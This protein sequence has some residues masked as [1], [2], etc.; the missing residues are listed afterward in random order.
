MDCLSMVEM[1]RKQRSKLP[2]EISRAFDSPFGLDK[3]L[4]IF[5]FNEFGID[6]RNTSDEGII[7]QQLVEGSASVSNPVLM[8]QDGDLIAD[9]I[10]AYSE[11]TQK[12]RDTYRLSLSSLVSEQ[13]LFPQGIQPFAVKQLYAPRFNAHGDLVENSYLKVELRA[14]VIE[15]DPDYSSM[16]TRILTDLFEVHVTVYQDAHEVGKIN[17]SLVSVK[18][19]VF[20]NRPV[21]KSTPTTFRDT[22]I[23]LDCQQYN[24]ELSG[25]VDDLSN[26]A[27][28]KAADRDLPQAT[29]MVT[30]YFLPVMARQRQ[31]MFHLHNVELDTE[32]RSELTTIL[33][34]V[35]AVFD[36]PAIHDITVYQQHCDYYDQDKW[37]ALSSKPDI[38]DNVNKKR[39]EWKLSGISVISVAVQKTWW[40]QSLVLYKPARA[41]LFDDIDVVLFIS[42]Q[43]KSANESNA[44]K[45]FNNE[46]DYEALYDTLLSSKKL[47]EKECCN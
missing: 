42:N 44:E 32:L 31:A 23:S 10:N 34:S 8:L 38:I 7:L 30:N 24:T 27:K 28:R 22:I 3:C 46:L 47:T 18:P 19:D 21:I 4:S 41:G 36:D 35:V 13:E 2:K 26:Y 11:L 15:P 17:A 20:D 1:L 25:V 14:P 39:A 40:Y 45:L 9:Q 33:D 43:T 12:M 5:L 37:T 6:L 29:A 16:S